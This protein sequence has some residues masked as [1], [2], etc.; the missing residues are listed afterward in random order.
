MDAEYVKLKSK[1]NDSQDVVE[2]VIDKLSALTDLFEFFEYTKGMAN[3][4]DK[5]IPGIY[6]IIDDCIDQ[7]GEIVK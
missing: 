3:F 1:L 7:L 5:A 6:Y 4:R 2:K